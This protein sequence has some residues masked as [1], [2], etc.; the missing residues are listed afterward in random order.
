[1]EHQISLADVALQPSD[2]CF[3]MIDYCIEKNAILSLILRMETSVNLILFFCIYGSFDNG[4]Q[5]KQ[6]MCPSSQV[7]MSESKRHQRQRACSKQ[8][9]RRENLKAWL[10]MKH[11]FSRAVVEA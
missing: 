6:F 8:K 4:L 5:T 11:Q 7:C 9:W 3:I 2:N 10:R 1:M